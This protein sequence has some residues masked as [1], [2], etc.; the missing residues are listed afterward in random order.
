MTFSEK[1]HKAKDKHGLSWQ[2]LAEELGVKYQ[3]VW[4]YERGSIKP[5]KAVVMLLD[6]LLARESKTPCKDNNPSV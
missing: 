4:A 3:S 6:N 5:R 1:L 2:Q